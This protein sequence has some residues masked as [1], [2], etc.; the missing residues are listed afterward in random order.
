MIHENKK[1]LFKVQ[2]FIVLSRQL[3]YNMSRS[4]TF[5]TKST[6]TPSEDTD[7]LA[8]TRGLI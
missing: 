7:Y 3:F 6:R 4:T 2:D 5:P 1:F 8:N